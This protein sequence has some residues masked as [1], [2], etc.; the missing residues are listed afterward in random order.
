[1]RRYF[2][3][4]TGTDIGKTWL[5]A[6]LCRHWT[7]AGVAVE[8]L[9]PVMS[10]YDPR[11]PEASDAGALLAALGRPVTEHDIARVA[12]WRFHAALSPDMAAAREGRV[13]DFERLVT[14]CRPPQSDLDVLLIEGVGGCMVPLDDMRTVRDWIKALD[15]PAVLIGGSYLGSLSH[16]LTA[17]AS[18]REMAVPLAALVVNE[19]VS[20]PVGLDETAAVLGRQA[21]GVPLFPIE[22]NDPQPG[23]A[24]LGEFLLGLA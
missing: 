24:R 3:T 11:N 13:I 6:A 7:A 2:I 16:T 17:L 15:M 12:P 23:I 18:L 10:G 4:G 21:P 1:M 20:S 22:R 14:F 5:T 9:K 8:A 19:S